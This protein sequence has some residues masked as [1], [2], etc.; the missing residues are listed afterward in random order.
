MTNDLLD[1]GDI[2]TNMILDFG[3]TVTSGI[4]TWVIICDNTAELLGKE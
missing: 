2:V 3:D 1:F 4:D